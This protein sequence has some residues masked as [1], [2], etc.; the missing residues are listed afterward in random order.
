VPR[1]SHDDRIAA[2]HGDLVFTTYLSSSVGEGEVTSQVEINDSGQTEDILAV[3]RMSKRI[4]GL[5]VSYAV[6][7]R[8]EVS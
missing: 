7:Q 2:I 1:L 6:P 4:Y 8:F 5:M 3:I